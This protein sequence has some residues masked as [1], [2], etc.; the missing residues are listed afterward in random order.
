[1][2]WILSIGGLVWILYSWSKGWH[3]VQ[4]AAT[5]PP[6]TPAAPAAGGPAT[7]TRWKKFSDFWKKRTESKTTK[8][9]LTFFAVLAVFYFALYS[10][11]P[12]SELF[13][14]GAGYG[15]L[16]TYFI[17]ALVAGLVDANLE[18]KAKFTA[19][20]LLFFTFAVFGP[21]AYRLLDTNGKAS[22]RLHLTGWHFGGGQVASS[23]L[24]TAKC[25]GVYE[26]HQLTPTP[27]PINGGADCDF[28]WEVKWGTV[29]F[30]TADGR[31][32]D[33]GKG[34]KRPG[35]PTRMVAW[36]SLDGPAIVHAAFCPR[37][38]H[39]NGEQCS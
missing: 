32:M 15:I 11:N 13:N 25:S 1:M 38:T 37:N 2:I 26:V 6:P 14:T 29:R 10:L 31:F 34:Q 16:G 7:Q 3:R 17:L 28:D 8:R 19:G 39:W 12:T 27:Q 23:T 33:V 9:V 4:S 20:V 22:A 35:P 24:S 30:T 36:Q 21:E 18:G 5:Q